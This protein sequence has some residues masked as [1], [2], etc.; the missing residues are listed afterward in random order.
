MRWLV[1]MPTAS[2]KRSRRRKSMRNFCVEIAP[3]RPQDV[4]LSTAKYMSTGMTRTVFWGW[5]TL[6]LHGKTS[7]TLLTTHIYLPWFFPPYLL[8]FN[9]L[10]HFITFDI[11]K[12]IY[13]GKISVGWSSILK[14]GQKHCNQSPSEQYKEYN[15]PWDKLFNENW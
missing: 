5:Q 2:P 7:Q 6:P 13:K 3:R 10:Y 15:G 8:L 14:N 12:I 4:K 9:S 11:Q 1:A